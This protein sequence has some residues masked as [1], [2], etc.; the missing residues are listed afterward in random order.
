MLR[1]WQALGSLRFTATSREIATLIAEVS[2]FVGLAVHDAEMRMANITRDGF[3]HAV[4]KLSQPVMS[5]PL[6]AFGSSCGTRLDIVVSQKRREPEQ[7]AEFIRGRNLTQSSVLVLLWPPMSVNGRVKWK[8]HCASERL[9]LLPLDHTLLLHLCGERNRLS[10]LLQLGLPCTWSRPYITK[11]ENVAREMF[12]GRRDEAAALMDPHGGCI[13]FGGRQLGKSAL[14][15]HVHNENHDPD[16][17]CFVNYMDVNDLGL[18]P[19][20]H[21]EMMTVFWR[22][23]HDQ[24]TQAA[25]IEGLPPE[26]LRR[27]RQL[28]NE[29]PLLIE[30]RLAE[31]ERARI[32]LLLDESDKLLDMDSGRNFALVRRLRALMAEHDRRFKVVFAG[33]QSVQR[34]NNWE[35]HPFAQLGKELVINPLPAPAAQDLIIR[36][37]RALGFAF[38]NPRLILPHSFAGQLS[39]G[40]DSDH[41]LPPSRQPLRQLAA[42]QLGQSRLHDHTAGRAR[43]GEGR[44]SD[45]GY[46]QSLRLDTRPRRPL[47]GADV[48]ASPNS[49]PERPAPGIGLH[50]SRKIVVAVRV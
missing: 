3:A 39:S 28:L 6:P 1:T 17:L 44:S 27:E 10:Q 23:V 24:L 35:N 7:V 8:R 29:V 47:Q 25:A 34:Y 46:S 20:T 37:L 31:D 12:V 49:R 18:E 22:R 36:P 30:K 19:Q 4:V 42:F 38:E 26:K 5:S 43:R 15:C 41:L 21:N 14:L 9:T 32:I 48:C 11:G 33:L 13:V 40:F 50:G 16:A 45:G 2:R